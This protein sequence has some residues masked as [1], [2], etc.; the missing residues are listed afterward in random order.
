MTAVLPPERT[1]FLKYWKIGIT[2]FYLV[3]AAA[4]V[5]IVQNEKDNSKKNQTLRMDIS[6]VEP[7]KTPPDPLPD[8][9]DFQTVRIGL[10]LEGIDNFSIKDSSWGATFY[11]WFSW[12]G[13]KSLDPGKSFQLVDAKI[14]RKELIDTYYGSDGT[15][16]QQYKVVAK[17]TKFFN[18]TRAPLDDH[19]LNIYIEDSSR[20]ASKLR[21][22]A[23]DRNNFSSRVNIPG[24]RITG[25]S[26]VVKAHTYNTSYGDP[27][28]SANVRKTY[29]E[30]VYA[31]TIKRSGMG[32]YFKIFIGLFAGVLLTLCS[33]FIRPSD[34]GPRYA[35]PS[36]SY[37][38][39]IAN[40]YM[41]HSMLPPS[42]YFGLTDLATGVGLLTISVCVITSLISGHYFL[43]KKEEDFSR[44]L[45]NLAWKFIGTGFL[46][47]NILMPICAFY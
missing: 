45:D 7:G 20:D 46:T 1:T 24:Y 40:A 25:F 27:R 19:M 2:I 15:N 18:T 30:F 11:L 16:Y 6:K 34:T 32:T 23:D 28:V 14:E 35:L 42:N 26:T 5:L 43:R 31:L 13:D 21:F 33:F 38:G 29:S 3:L 37:F 9:T 8:N 17:V 4:V 36:A 22:V 47:I 12:Q 41:T 39:I 44:A 10:Y